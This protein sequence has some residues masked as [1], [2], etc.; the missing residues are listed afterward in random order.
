MLYR[1]GAVEGEVPSLIS[2][3]TSSLKYDRKIARATVKVVL[4]H[5]EHLCE[6]NAINKNVC[7]KILSVLKKLYDEILEKYPRGKFED[8]HEYIEYYVINELG[9]DIGGY[10]NLGKSRNDQVVTAIRMVLKDEIIGLLEEI[11]KLQHTLLNKAKENIDTLAPGYT[12]Q[13]KAQITTVAHHLLAF[14]DALERDYERIR[15]SLERVDASPLGSAA[16]T[17]N[18]IPGYD[19][20]KVARMLGFSKIVENTE[21]AIASRDFVLETIFNIAVLMSNVSRLVED[22]IL[23]SMNELGYVE[24]PEHHVATSSIMPHKRNPVTLE[25]IR[26]RVAKILGNVTSAY[27]LLKSLPYSYNLDLQELTPI[28]WETIDYCKESLAILND[29]LSKIRLNKERLLKS[30]SESITLAFSD[31]AEYITLK[32]KVPFRRIHR[33]LGE[34]SKRNNITSGSVS[35][36]LKEKLNID[37]NEAELE[38]ILNPINSLRRKTVV[39]SPSP[40]KTRELIDKRVKSLLEKESE[41]FKLRSKS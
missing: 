24:L 14:Y 5:V 16:M 9:E 31:L 22:L 18:S 36:V 38:E 19:R 15:E 29:L 17:G 3:F 2:N 11:I 27:A 26:A 37:I 28:L 10:V 1:K 8:I 33:V 39:G 32:Y 35:S 34:I 7:S 23:W 30:I 41:L 4:V 12:H 21:D 13:Q 20:V 6:I 40:D 25:I